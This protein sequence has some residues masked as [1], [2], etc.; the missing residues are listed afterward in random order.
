[1]GARRAALTGLDGRRTRAWS[2]PP[3]CPEAAGRAYFRIVELEPDKQYVWGTVPLTVDDQSITSNT[4]LGRDL[5]NGTVPFESEKERWRGVDDPFFKDALQVVAETLPTDGK[6]PAP[7]DLRVL[8]RAQMG[9]LLLWSILERYAA[10]RYHLAGESV[11]KVDYIA[12]ETAFIEGIRKYVR[13]P[14]EVYRADNPDADKRCRLTPDNPKKALR[15][16]Y[17]VRSN[18]THRGKGAVQDFRHLVL[19]SQ[20]LLAIAT[21]VLKSAFE[22]AKWPGYGD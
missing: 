3:L 6:N 8:F 18:A 9:Y 20:E 13:E 16:Y 21:D 12:T 22:E 19:S 11:G 10:L 1:L 2:C 5:S 15:Y 17:Q 14:R 7:P 4:L